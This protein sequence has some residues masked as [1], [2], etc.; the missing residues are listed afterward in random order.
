MNNRIK[1]I[2]EY[3]NLSASRFA[4]K[5]NTQ[6]S[7]ISHILS[8]RN[9]PS[10]DLL[11]KIA[12]NFNE[13]NMSWLITGNGDM[14]SKENTPYFDDELTAPPLPKNL[15]LNTENSIEDLFSQIDQDDQRGSL[16]NDG[17]V[18][19]NKKREGGLEI[20]KTTL[21]KEIEQITIFYK[22]GSFKNYTS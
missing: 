12:L 7:S 9:K 20:K 19:D 5:L 14:I 15:H 1:Q 4:D 2:L 6:P 3:F 16:S 22:D 13:I 17:L 18:L 10:I 21:N 8:G 11:E